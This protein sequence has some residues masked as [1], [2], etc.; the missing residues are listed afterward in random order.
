MSVKGIL[1]DSGKVLNG[2][3]TGH[4]F[5]TP[6]FFDY[7][8]KRSFESISKD[9]VKDAFKKATKYISEQSTILTEKEEYIHFQKF[10]SI[11]LEC[12]PE[13]KTNDEQVNLITRDLVFNYKKY[14][15]YDEV[16]G[17]LSE[18]HSRFK[19]AIVSDAWPSLENVFV[20]AG[21]R[22]YFSSFIISSKL[23]VVKPNRL[24]YET[25]LKELNLLPEEVIFVDDNVKNC[26]G[27]K[28]LGI[29]TYL[30]CRNFTSYT[31]HKLKSKHHKVVK[32]LRSIF[33]SI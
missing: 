29:D 28:D 31:Y 23:G 20:D 15:F 12:L 33:K 26:D 10:Y 13:I 22:D 9:R 11:F 3:I 8:D 27:A 16:D 21:Y 24:M 17:L 19:L 18:M 1:L 25:A 6:N 32:N 30:L 5:I 4:W 14:K 7:V 2:P